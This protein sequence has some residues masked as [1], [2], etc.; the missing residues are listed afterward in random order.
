MDFSDGQRIHIWFLCTLRITEEISRK[1]ISSQIRRDD[2]EGKFP[3]YL[4]TIFLALC[5]Q[6][7]TDSSFLY[8]NAQYKFVLIRDTQAKTTKTNPH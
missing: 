8:L 6:C 1:E 2:L 3:Q 4:S 7:Y 5:P